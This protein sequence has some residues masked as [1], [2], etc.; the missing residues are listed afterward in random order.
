M[1]YEQSDAFYCNRHYKYLHVYLPPCVLV[2]EITILSNTLNCYEP[3]PIQFQY[4]NLTVNG[5]LKGNI[6]LA[7]TSNIK[8]QMGYT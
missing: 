1:S 7:K 6:I 4:N 8:H 5:F 2:S 3:V